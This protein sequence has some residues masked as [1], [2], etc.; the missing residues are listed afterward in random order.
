MNNWLSQQKQVFVTNVALV[1]VYCHA[2]AKL[3]QKMAMYSI[4]TQSTI[5]GT[6]ILLCP[7]KRG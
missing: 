3:M 4:I 2:G 5:D 6:N 7:W 1:A